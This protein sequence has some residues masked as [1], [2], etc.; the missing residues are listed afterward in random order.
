MGLFLY[1]CLVSAYLPCMWRPCSPVYT[2]RCHGADDTP[3][4]SAGHSD[5]PPSSLRQ[6][7]T[8]DTLRGREATQENHFRTKNRDN[9]VIITGETHKIFLAVTVFYATLTSVKASLLIIAR[10]PL[11]VRT[12]GG[13]R[14]VRRVRDHRDRRRTSGGSVRCWH[15]C[16]S[17]CTAFRRNP[18]DSLGTTNTVQPNG[19]TERTRASLNR[20]ADSSPSWHKSPLTPGGQRQL[21]V[22]GSQLAPFLHLQWNEQFLPKNPSEHAGRKTKTKQ[23]QY[24]I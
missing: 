17:C 15:S 3:R 8:W 12:H 22:T 10:R 14:S 18:S 23:K 7:S 24:W 21:P 19:K 20:Q 1:V 11:D 2:H 13:G 6:R 5:T 9:S 16:T 4:N